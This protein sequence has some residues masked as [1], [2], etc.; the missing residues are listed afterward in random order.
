M[1]GDAAASAAVLRPA[2]WLDGQDSNP[3]DEDTGIYFGDDSSSTS[4]RQSHITGR[5][6]PTSDIGDLI[7][8]TLSS[9]PPPGS[10]PV[11]LGQ[12]VARLPVAGLALPEIASAAGSD[13]PWDDSHLGPLIRTDGSAV[14]PKFTDPA[15]HRTQGARK[16]PPTG[17]AQRLIGISF[18]GTVFLIVAHIGLQIFAPRLLPFEITDIPAMVSD[19]VGPLLKRLPPLPAL[20]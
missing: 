11:S 14:E 3:D 18:T 19:A 20:W 16:T 15:S 10:E 2:P 8:K 7:S 1:G 5:P 4:T 6:Q 17:R 13:S 12:G 9:H